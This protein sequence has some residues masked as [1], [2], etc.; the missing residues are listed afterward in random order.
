MKG[1]KKDS[2][3]DLKSI[4]VIEKVRN[5]MYTVFTP[6]FQNFIIGTGKTIEEA[7]IDF[8]NSVKEIGAVYQNN[9]K[10]LPK[11]LKSISFE[12]KYD[13]ASL[14]DNLDWINVSK[15]AKKAKINDSLM[16]RY[17]SGEYI[18]Q[19]QMQ[20]IE[21]TLHDLGKVI[22]EIKLTGCS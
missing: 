3:S 18:S 8:E 14:F 16:R 6:N 17:R 20:K 5:R 22:S 1:L 13:I 19:N 11:E 7:K 21:K 9:N 2:R 4:A 15:F 12:Y 10:Q